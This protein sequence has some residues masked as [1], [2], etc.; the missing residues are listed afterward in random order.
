MRV[1]GNLR[2][3]MLGWVMVQVVTSAAVHAQATGPRGTLAQLDS[4]SAAPSSSSGSSTERV[5]QLAALLAGSSREKTKLSAI[6]ALARYGDRRA[7]QPLVGA[8]TDDSPTVRALAATALGKLGQKAALPALRQAANDTDSTVRARIGEAIRSIT[9]A[10]GLTQE[11]VGAEASAGAG[12]GRS[13]RVTENNP[14]L[15]VVVKTCND[16]SPGRT[17]KKTRGIHAEVVRAAMMTQLRGAPLVTAAASDARRLSL[18]PRNVDAS[19]VK[20]TLR[21]KGRFLEIETELRLAIS[22]SN[23]K[24]L[25]FLSGGAKVSVPKKG[26]NWSFLPQLRKEAIENAVRGLFDKLIAHLRTTVAA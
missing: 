10:N 8:L 16:D 21:T 19:V 2:W 25:S 7:V 22:D 14:D 13:A 1:R 26:F 5:Q 18:D 15:Y 17:D 6:A 20:M 24:M 12:F 23:G 3:A 9:K 11:S 4:A